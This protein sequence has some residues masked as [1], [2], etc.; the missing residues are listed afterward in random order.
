MK[1]NHKEKKAIEK[2]YNEPW[3]Y[4][5]SFEHHIEPM[6]NSIMN[7]NTLSDTEK[8][9]LRLSAIYHDV[10]YDPLRND[11]EELSNEY[12]L[13]DFNHDDIYKKVS[14]I[15]LATKTHKSN[16]ELVRKF[17]KL[18]LA[19]FEGELF[20]VINNQKLIRREYQVYEL[21]EFK[22]GSIKVLESFL[23]SDLLS[24]KAKDNIK[25]NIEF[26]KSWIPKIGMICGSFDPLTIG[27][28]DIIKKSENIFDEVIIVFSKNFSKNSSESIIPDSLK[29]HR[30]IKYDGAINDLLV[31]HNYPITLIRGLRN[32]SDFQAEMNYQTFLKEINPDINVVNIFSSPE[33]IHISSTAIRELI[34]V[35]GIDSN[36]VKK[37]LA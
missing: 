7:D 1:Y 26:T 18:D 37:Y 5:H 20:N 24:D 36:L 4:Y 16:D 19:N 33:Y 12:F 35:Y 28:M 9:I 25:H 32:T 2:M 13:N 10:I 8:T 30:V 27:H 15:I 14:E 34:K 29:Y 31:S 3:R 17:L 23:N 6:I 11:N 21:N 22:N